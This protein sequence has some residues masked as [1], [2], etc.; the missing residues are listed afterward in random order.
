MSTKQTQKTKR[1]CSAV[2]IGIVLAALSA[3]C[4]NPAG[5]NSLPAAVRAEAA[6]RAEAVRE[7][8]PQLPL[9]KAAPRLS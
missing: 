3:G 9:S 7:H 4:S 1:C 8:R 6:H 5:G 2:L